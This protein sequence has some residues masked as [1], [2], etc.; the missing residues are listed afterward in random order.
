MHQDKVCVSVRKDP[1]AGAPRR[2][3]CKRSSQGSEFFLRR[4]YLP[5][6]PNPSVSKA[7]VMIRNKILQGQSTRGF[8]P[9]GVVVDRA[10]N[11]E[12]KEV[13]PAER[14]YPCASMVLRRGIMDGIAGARERATPFPSGAVPSGGASPRSS[15]E[16]ES[17][18]I[19]S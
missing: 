10:N 18:I 1:T 6:T 5:P 17:W 9:D 14:K 7:L 13:R 12:F 3:S 15:F 19:C 2:G 11:F 16:I 8:S 4:H